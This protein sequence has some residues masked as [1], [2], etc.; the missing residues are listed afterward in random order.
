[1]RLRSLF[2]R[3]LAIY[4]AGFFI[5]FLCSLFVALS[6]SRII[7]SDML[8]RWEIAKE[9]GINDIADSISDITVLNRILIGSGDLGRLSYFREGD[10]TRGA[11]LSLREAGNV[12]TEAGIII[13]DFSYAFALFRNN[14]IFLSSGPDTLAFSG[15]FGRLMHAAASG[16]EIKSGDEFR[17]LLFSSYP[18]GLQYLALDR[19]DYVINDKEESLY[20]PILFLLSTEGIFGKPEY[21]MVFVLDPERIVER[22]LDPGIKDY[23]FL[24]IYSDSGECLLSY[25]NIPAEIAG[26]ID[27]EL[28]LEVNDYYISEDSVP[29][30]GWK[31]V[32]GV[33]SD[34]ILRQMFPVIRILVIYL[35]GGLLLA[36]ILSIFFSMKR[37]GGFRHIYSD[38]LESSEPI[39]KGNEYAILSTSIQ[40]IKDKGEEYKKQLED[41]SRQNAAINLLHLVEFGIHDE[42]DK[43]LFLRIFGEE[44]TSYRVAVIRVIGNEEGEYEKVTM[45]FLS[46]L[47]SDGLRFRSVHDG[48]GNEIIV[49]ALSA[50]SIP[51]VSMLGTASSSISSLF[52]AV[53]HCGLSQSFSSLYRID[54]AFEEARQIVRSL[55]TEE[56]EN[57]VREYDPSLAAYE[58]NPVSLDV[59]E[60]LSAF[61][62]CGK[63]EGA[64]KILDEIESKLSSNAFMFEKRKVQIFFALEN[65]FSSMSSG[66]SPVFVE[67]ASSRVNQMTSETMIGF[68]RVW[69]EEIGRNFHDRKK[70]HNEEL[71]D[72][73]IIYVN[74][75]YSEPGLSAVSVASDMG[76]SEK[77]LSQFL[78]EQ[79][80]ASFS[81]YLRKVR[82]EAAI[83]YLENTEYSNETIAEL[84]GFGGVNTFYRNFS[85]Q[86]GVTP[87]VY[88]DNFLNHKE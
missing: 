83:R 8:T 81:E 39:D 78:K 6:S 30:I 82:I 5:M 87:K 54:G 72:R 77:Y 50:D 3:F 33:S 73:I 9:Q 61:L 53:I 68:F 17:S 57:I 2:F 58:D 44:G 38:V 60:K 76:I 51:L 16:K 24:S 46:L 31:I 42:D 56:A 67:D 22:I 49:F 29:S 64:M 86:M 88:K 65:I 21:I 74:E 10:D 45:E 19:L 35:I 1:M 71:R 4:L 55:Y 69:G 62:A 84:T 80:G 59:L 26:N 32:A 36:I 43:A 52:N 13:D 20:N 40:K 15:Y 18:G 41:L 7:R 63:I 11:V 48:E 34:Y 70:S 27:D 66:D 23:S 14:D 75:H 85:R 47:S 79:T 12:F 28:P 25:G 37:F